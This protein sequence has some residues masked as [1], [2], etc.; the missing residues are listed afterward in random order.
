MFL[1]TL[2]P[3]NTFKII[4]PYF[5]PIN[6][7]V[8]LPKKSVVLKKILLSTQREILKNKCILVNFSVPI[9]L[10]N[11]FYSTVN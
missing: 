2:N 3:K 5:F 9:K 11:L 1:E 4:Y 10:K 7:L 6:N 8:S